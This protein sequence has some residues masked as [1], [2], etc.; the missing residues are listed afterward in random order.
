MLDY[1]YRVRAFQCHSR[2]RSRLRSTC[3][4]PTC[5]IPSPPRPT[6][7]GRP[8]PDRL[9]LSDPS[10]TEL[11]PMLT[12]PP[13]SAPVNLKCLKTLRFMN[14]AGNI[15][16]LSDDTTCCHLRSSH[17]LKTSSFK[18]SCNYFLGPSRLQDTLFLDV[19]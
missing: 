10:Q 13:S 16:H 5:P 19:P 4:G 9:G 1:S 18:Y 3:P 17:V 8:V 2:P 14:I 11:W 7:P 15:P 12:W 6:Q